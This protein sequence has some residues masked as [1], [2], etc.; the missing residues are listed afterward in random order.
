MLT[1]YIQY[2]QYLWATRPWSARNHWEI[3]LRIK[4][5]KLACNID[6]VVICCPLHLG[7]WMLFGVVPLDCPCCDNMIH[8]LNHTHTSTTV[9][10]TKE[11]IQWTIAWSKS[12]IQWVTVCK[13]LQIEEC[14]LLACVGIRE[15]QWPTVPTLESL[16]MISKV[17]LLKS[18]PQLYRHIVVI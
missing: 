14:Q 17:H 6:N 2:Q 8:S 15:C 18:L 1:L 16:D 4:N 12:S 3:S 7:C 10:T 13:S 5:N 9:C 11:N